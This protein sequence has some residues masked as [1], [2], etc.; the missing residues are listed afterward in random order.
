VATLAACPAE[1]LELMLHPGCCDARSVAY[2][3]DPAREDELAALLDPRFAAW[4]AREGVTSTH[5]GELA[6]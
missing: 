5:Y 6:P 3:A 4:L 2:S 1:S